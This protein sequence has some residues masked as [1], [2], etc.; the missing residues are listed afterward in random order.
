ML[1]WVHWCDW[2][3]QELVNYQSENDCRLAHK[4]KVYI[5]SMYKNIWSDTNE[6]P[7]LENGVTDIRV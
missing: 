7:H 1:V 6:L 3:G 4:N 2:G 5:K